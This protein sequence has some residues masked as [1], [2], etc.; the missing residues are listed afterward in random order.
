MPYLAAA[1]ALYDYDPQAEEELAVS[2]GKVVFVSSKSD[3]P[4]WNCKDIQTGNTGLVPANYLEELDPSTADLVPSSFEYSAQEPDELTFPESANLRVLDRSDPDW[5]VC[6]LNGQVGLVPATYLEGGSSQD[7]DVQDDGADSGQPDLAAASDGP[8]QSRFADLPSLGNS[9]ADSDVPTDIEYWKVTELDPKKKKQIRSGLIGATDVS[10]LLVNDARA[11]VYFKWALADLGKRERKG[12]RVHLHFAGGE[13]RIFEPKEKKEAEALLGKIE[14]M[15]RLKK[16]TFTASKPAVAASKLGTALYDYTPDPST[17]AGDEIAVRENDI[18]MVLEDDDPDWMRVRL[19]AKDGRSG[20]GMVPRSYV[21]VKK[22]G[23]AGDGAHSPA[24]QNG[25]G[26][27]ME[28]VAFKL[29]GS[30]SV[31]PMTT[32]PALPR[33]KIEDDV[34]APGS[35]GSPGGGG[36]PKSLPDQ[37]KVRTWTDKTGTFKV[38]AEFLT[39]GEG[40]VNLHKTNGVKIAVPLEKLCASDQEFVRSINA[41]AAATPRASSPGPKL[42]A[43]TASLP[44]NDRPA[45]PSREAT[46]SS[47]NQYVYNGFDWYEFLTAKAAIN[48][49]DARTYAATF[50]RE[51]IDSFTLNGLDVDILKSMGV[52]SG[53]IIRVRKAA[54]AVADGGSAE[55][56]ALGPLPAV[57][58]AH[59]AREREA[60]ERN[61]AKLGL[62]SGNMQLRTDEEIARS[63]QEEEYRAA[64][65]VP[66]ASMMH[67]QS[68]SP[69]PYAALR[70]GNKPAIAFAA[71][72]AAVPRRSSGTSKAP[73]TVDAAF[74]K[75]AQQK[76]SASST[77]AVSPALPRRPASSNAMPNSPPSPAPNFP[78]SD[79]DTPL[80]ATSPPVHAP[81]RKT[82]SQLSLPAATTSVTSFAGSNAFPPADE[83]NNTKALSSSHGS[84]GT[85]PPSS[86]GA[87]RKRPEPSA[88]S[89]LSLP[90]AATMASATTRPSSVPPPQ[91]QR[92]RNTAVASPT[93]PS[94]QPLIPAPARPSL[95]YAPQQTTNRPSAVAAPPPAPVPPPMPIVQSTPP[96]P[97]QSFRPTLV[98]AQNPPAPQP[99]PSFQPSLVNPSSAGIPSTAGSFPSSFASSA[100]VAEPAKPIISAPHPQ[101]MFPSS[102]PTGPLQG[103]MSPY[104][105]PQSASPAPTS[106]SSVSTWQQPPST[107]VGS[108]SGTSS[109]QFGQGG[110]GIVTQSLGPHLGQASQSFQPQL[111]QA[112]SFIPNQSMGPPPPTPS[113]ANKPSSGSL[114]PPLIPTAP[115]S[116]GPRPSGQPNFIGQAMPTAGSFGAQM[117]ASIGGATNTS[118]GGM[119]G[120]S[121]PGTPGMGTPI[122]GQGM[123]APGIGPQGMGQQGLGIGQPGMGQQGMVHQGMVQQGLPIGQ[124]G[125]GQP[126]TSFN[127][128]TGSQ[129]QGAAFGGMGPSHTGTT[130]MASMQ[131]HPTFGG[132]VLGSGPGSILGTQSTN[133]GV[134]SLPSGGLGGSFGNLASGI[135]GGS[136]S[137]IASTSGIGGP[138]TFLPLPPS[139]SSIGSGGFGGS[140]QSQGA[141]GNMGGM[142]QG[143][144]GLGGG[145][146]G[147]GGTQQGMGSGS[148]GMVGMQQGI[149]GGSMGMGGMQ[150]GMGS[151]TLGMGGMPGMAGMQSGINQQGMQSGMQVMQSAM[152]PGMQQMQPGMQHGVQNMGMGPVLGFTGMSNMQNNMQGMS[153]LQGG[154]IGGPPQQQ[155]TLGL[156]GVGYRR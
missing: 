136:G 144:G 145:S 2:E 89:D 34:S 64:G 125:A 72:N 38:D 102:N 37:A 50:V 5:W 59:R 4:W 104:V 113:L 58:G 112:G 8:V 71:K 146:M 118:F 85:P 134:Q 133:R 152:S 13:E 138:K 33:R 154:F 14:E 32:A 22:T 153:G 48:P 120:N 20:E 54:A 55:S 111:Q 105:L 65:Q 69:D 151:G 28:D 97:V 143:P 70:G 115:N 135:A 15:A 73:T 29:A 24:L 53:D 66:P 100:L 130:G 42:P 49:Q 56:K 75:D 62:D 6:S 36:S 128:S 131:P 93:P 82:S 46:S 101:Q 27:V 12:K 47:S 114:P 83:F 90:S 137:S 18:L 26:G 17:S 7:Q 40:K 126:V 68:D 148:M 84:L 21:E 147:M 140:Q 78:V 25:G 108:F 11:L 39:F 9:S 155:G 98:S 61:L 91:T 127:S 52:A 107:S 123:S 156:N 150:Q 149:G 44:V 96:A 76:L 142:Q 43:R 10:I 79:W 106:I 16:A 19:V 3:E 95:N 141:F 119:Q 92:L 103:G 30:V 117:N 51:K 63:L 121:G 80:H 81:L 109:Q 41:E 132:Q 23:D 45:L 122:L 110:S 60:A 129:M 35:P 1:R 67:A 74:V 77:P 88:K 86:P 139:A 94:L 116:F 57:G 124:Q 31:P 87:A 99:T